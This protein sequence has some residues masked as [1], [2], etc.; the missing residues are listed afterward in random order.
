LAS[1]HWVL[2]ATHAPLKH[3]T[4]V[5]GWQPL[6]NGTGGQVV[7][8]DTQSPLEHLKGALAGQPVNSLMQSFAK[9]AQ[10]PLGQRTGAKTGHVSIRGQAKAVSRQLPS[11]HRY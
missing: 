5:A 7:D 3:L 9:G 8:E 10:T 6:D 2:V 4:G 11:S 1:L